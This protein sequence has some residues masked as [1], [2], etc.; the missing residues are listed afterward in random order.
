MHT[1]TIEK[2]YNYC[3]NRSEYAAWSSWSISIPRVVSKIILHV[4]VFRQIRRSNGSRSICCSI[5]L[6][7]SFKCLLKTGKLPYTYPMPNDGLTYF[8][9]RLHTDAARDGKCGLEL[10]RLL[11]FFSKVYY[12]RTWRDRQ[13]LDSPGHIDKC[14]LY[15]GNAVI[16]GQVRCHRHCPGRCTFL[17]LAKISTVYCI[18]GKFDI[19][20]K[21]YLGN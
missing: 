15:S 3:I 21:H 12:L 2:N 7:N 10:M 8:R 19:H 18:S 16:L 1:V 9:W 17:V 5:D 14:H 20:S 11:L 13:R 4:H 6:T